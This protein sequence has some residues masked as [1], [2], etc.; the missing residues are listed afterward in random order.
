L[1]GGKSFD[2]NGNAY[3][4]DSVETYP[5]FPGGDEE[6]IRFT[7]LNIQF[8]AE[9]DN[10]ITKPVLVRVFVGR[11]GFVGNANI[12]RGA[13]PYMNGEA[14]RVAKILPRFLPA[15]VRG[16]PVDSYCTVPIDFLD[17]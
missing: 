16:Q 12:I 10:V 1:V 6:L 13:T 14:L 7:R 4:Y 9:K 2:G 5:R 3:S 8:P 15:T 11:N 17:R